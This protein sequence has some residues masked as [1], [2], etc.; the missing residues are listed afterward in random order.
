MD[1]FSRRHDGWLISVA[2]EEGT[3]PRR[4]VV[5]DVPLHGVVAELS[6]HTASMMI[7]AGETTHVVKRPAV[8]TLDETEEGADVEL[9]IVDATG[10]RTIIEFRSPMRS[11]LV[12]GLAR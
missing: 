8:L 4:Y 7:F 2:I 1:A 5:R 3:A 12:D 9:A 11:E 6:D 10:E